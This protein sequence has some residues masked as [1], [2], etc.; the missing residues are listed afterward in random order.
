[1]GF[2][3]KFANCVCEL[4][5]WFQSP[6]W[7]FGLSGMGHQAWATMCIWLKQFMNWSLQCVEGMNTRTNAVASNKLNGLF[8]GLRQINEIP[9][10]L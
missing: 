6:F 1:M 4:G 10:L 5:R 7:C 2:Y 8:P 3:L 9:W